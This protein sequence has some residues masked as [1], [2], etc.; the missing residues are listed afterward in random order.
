[1]ITRFF[2]RLKV[3]F[4]YARFSWTQYDW[5][6]GYLYDIMAWKMRRM[7]DHLSNKAVSVQQ[8]QDLAA[9]VQAATVCERLKENAYD[10]VHWDAHD[11]KWGKSEITFEDIPNTDTCKM[12]FSKRANVTPEN[13]EQQRAE[14]L[15]CAT[16]A[17]EDRKADIDQLARLLKDY[18]PTWWD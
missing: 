4:E 8:P 6:E 13:E 17:D 15:E 10:M 14:Y 1:M 2:R 18:A 3:A 11:V 5:D 16:K 12:L 7:H 9:L